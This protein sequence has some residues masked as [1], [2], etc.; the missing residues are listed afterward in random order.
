MTRTLHVRVGHTPDRTDLASDL[1]AL[2]D[3]EA[4]E[5]AEPTLGIPDLETFGRVFRATNLAVLEAI[6]AHEPDSIR[7]LARTLDRHPPE[8][9]ENVHELSN[10]GLVELREEGRATR[11]V[12]RY[13]S[14]AVELSLGAEPTDATEA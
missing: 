14:V 10:Y 9:L 2:D 11:P 5:P 6:V 3:G 1:A 13:D 7:E 12:V 4:V 8:V